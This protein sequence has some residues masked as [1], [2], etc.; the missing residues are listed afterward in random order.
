MYKICR[1]HL[2]PAFLFIRERLKLIF[3]KTIAL[4]KYNTI[5]VNFFSPSISIDFSNLRLFIFEIVGMEKLQWLKDVLGPRL[6][7]RRGEELIGS[8]QWENMLSSKAQAMI[9]GRLFMLNRDFFLSKLDFQAMQP[10]S[11][12]RPIWIPNPMLRTLFPPLQE[13]SL[14][15]CRLVAPSFSA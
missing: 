13:S 8:I 6:E 14:A 4:Q 11:G 9:A 15:R 12:I 10:L 2:R 3:H 7:I 1:F 5:T